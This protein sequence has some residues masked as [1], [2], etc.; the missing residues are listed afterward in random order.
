MK[1]VCKNCWL[2]HLKLLLIND[3]W[4]VVWII[5]TDWSWLEK[6]KMFHVASNILPLKIAGSRDL[7]LLLQF[8]ASNW[9]GLSHWNSIEE[10]LSGCSGPMFLIIPTNNKS[11]DV[12]PDICS[13]YPLFYAD[14]IDTLVT[15]TNKSIEHLLWKF[16]IWICQRKSALLC[17]SPETRES[18]LQIEKIILL[19]LE[20]MHGDDL[21]LFNHWWRMQWLW[22]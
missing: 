18:E 19:G 22:W 17:N 13:N 6:H 14:N 16:N 11:C 10:G 3:L 7:G 20:I 2:K 5:K 4:D 15:G 9:I 21:K 12:N 1:V 8:L